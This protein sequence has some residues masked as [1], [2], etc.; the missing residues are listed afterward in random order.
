VRTVQEAEKLIKELITKINCVA[1]HGAGGKGDS[2]AAV[3]LNP[4][5]AD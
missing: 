5:P 4:K 1:C 3:A 2:P